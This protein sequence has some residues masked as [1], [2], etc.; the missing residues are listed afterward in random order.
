MSR[1]FHETHPLPEAVAPWTPRALVATEPVGLAGAAAPPGLSA[2]TPLPCLQAVMGC[3][4][5][6]HGLQWAGARVPWWGAQV[7]RRGPEGQ[8]PSAVLPTERSRPPQVMS[9]QQGRGEASSVRPPPPSQMQLG[10]RG[11]EPLG[12]TGTLC[13]TALWWTGRDPQ[14]GGLTEPTLWR[15]Q[16]EGWARVPLPLWPQSPRQAFIKL[17]SGWWAGCPGALSE[18]DP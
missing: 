12:P 6:L 7:Q 18:W 1:C 10:W 3:R 11:S 9:P 13:A 17:L 4:G 8:W 2:I 15:A 14:T 16:G 5:S